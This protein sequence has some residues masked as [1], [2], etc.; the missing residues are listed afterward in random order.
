MLPSL[1]SYRKT[2]T[3]LFGDLLVLA[4]EEAFYLRDPL[5]HHP[6]LDK[7]IDQ[8]LFF[9]DGAR[10]A[11]L[12]SVLQT[13]VLETGRGRH[14]RLKGV[15][16]DRNTGHVH[17]LTEPCP[18]GAQILDCPFLEQNIHAMAAVL[19][20][21]QTGVGFSLDPYDPFDPL[22]SHFKKVFYPEDCADM[23]NDLPAGEIVFKADWDLKMVLHNI[24]AA[25]E[26]LPS[27]RPIEDLFR[28]YP[29]SVANPVIT[30]LW[31][32]AEAIEVTETESSLLFHHVDLRVKAANMVVD[33]KSKT[34]LT[35]KG[36]VPLAIKEFLREV[37]KG[38]DTLSAH[39][40]SFRFLE[41]LVIAQE[42][43]RFLLQR[44]VI[45]NR[46]M[47]HG[48]EGRTLIGVAQNFV[49]SHGTDLIHHLGSRAV[50]YFANYSY[51]WSCS[52]RGIYE[53]RVVDM[54]L[55]PV[56]SGSGES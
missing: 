36:R 56:I 55:F 37:N 44:K 1:S 7:P 32:S 3:A 13:F 54:C 17:W 12:E 45:H 33:P 24:D 29:V 30:R 4:S 5:P 53:Y 34:G 42:A 18:P 9:K 28:R 15:S 50:I 47:L 20:E 27:L 39:I 49:R 16:L 25:A 19:R 46:V 38:M 48:A 21:C 10:D 14:K 11:S 22:G 35:E 31:L 52:S 2:C 6:D 23:W 51:P 26:V 43:V 41:Q 8:P 40:P